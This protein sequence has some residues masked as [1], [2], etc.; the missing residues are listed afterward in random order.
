[1]L[2]NAI[3][4]FAAL[5]SFCIYGIA[6]KYFFLVAGGKLPPKMRCV[7]VLGMIAAGVHLYGLAIASPHSSL[8][9]GI[10][11]ALYIAGITL[12]GWAY[13]VTRM[14][15]LPVAFSDQKVG[16]VIAT[17]PYAWV[18][19]PFYVSYSLTWI[20]GVVATS[21]IDAAIAAGVMIACYM[22]MAISEERQLR[23]SH[24]D[25]YAAYSSQVG[26]I[27]PRLRRFLHMV[28]LSAKNRGAGHVR[29]EA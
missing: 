3:L 16:A 8:R 11:I 2:D 25:E 24:R 10:A 4:I 29:G 1:M 28:G 14:S 18:R 7:G 15:R 20:A 17:G 19:H 6:I 23:A 26:M 9:M 21:R 13:R 5:I 22:T 12:F 27:A